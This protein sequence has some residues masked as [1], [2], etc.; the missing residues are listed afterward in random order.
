M[1]ILLR[2]MF[3]APS[4]FICGKLQNVKYNAK[5]NFHLVLVN[6]TT[7]VLQ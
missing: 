1:T 3:T 6:A 4:M 5:T 2:L 7:T